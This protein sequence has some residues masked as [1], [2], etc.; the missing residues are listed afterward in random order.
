M[1]CDMYDLTYKNFI[2][3]FV[4]YYQYIL[5]YLK[6]G[7]YCK[8]ISQVVRVQYMCSWSDAFLYGHMATKFLPVMEF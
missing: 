6:A 5:T 3:H 7:I 4:S 2:F 1:P 8:N